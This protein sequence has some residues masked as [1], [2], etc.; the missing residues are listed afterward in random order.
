MKGVNVVDGRVTYRAVAES[1][2]LDYTDPSELL[3]GEPAMA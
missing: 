1:F 3:V 2:N